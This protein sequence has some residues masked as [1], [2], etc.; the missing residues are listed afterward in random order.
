[1]LPAERWWKQSNGASSITRTNKADPEESTSHADNT[2]WVRGGVE[3]H[4]LPVQIP[5][6]HIKAVRSSSG[7]SNFDSL[8]L[9]ELDMDISIQQTTTRTNNT[10]NIIEV[11]Y[12]LN[13]LVVCMQTLEHVQCTSPNDSSHEYNNLQ[14]S[15]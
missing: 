14:C 7:W 9:V 10:W 3:Q 5:C 8:G 12:P 6:L 11:M 13:V 4:S 15:S 1:M 2:Y